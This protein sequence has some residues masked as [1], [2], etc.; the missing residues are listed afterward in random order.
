[1]C[2]CVGVRSWLCGCVHVCRECLKEAKANKTKGKSNHLRLYIVIHMPIYIYIYT[3]AD[4]L[5]GKAF[6]ETQ[7]HT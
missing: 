5:T 1:M 3:N 7:L 6:D 2:V 4:G